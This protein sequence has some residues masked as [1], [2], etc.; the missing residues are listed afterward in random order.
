MA[1]VNGYTTDYVDGIEDQLIVSGAVVAGHLILTKN[2]ASTID[3]G[4]VV[5]SSPDASTTVKGIV[6]LADSTE[7]AALSDSTRAITPAGLAGVIGGINT[8]LSGK[9]A[10]DADLTTIAGLTPVA[11][12]FLQY[13]SGAWA[14]RTAAQ[15]AVD[16]SATALQPKDS[17]LTA[18][19]AIAPANDDVIQR[20]AGAWTNRTI[21]Q[22]GADLAVTDLQPKDSD[23][24]A[25]AAIAPTNDDI[26]QRKAGA[27]I[28]RTVAQYKSDLAL[29]NVD[30]T[31]DTA[32]PVSTAQQTALNLKANLAAPTI[33]GTAVF[34]GVISVT[35]KIVSPSVALSVSASLV[36]TDANLGN[37]FRVAATANFTLSNPTNP[38]DGQV[39]EWEI[40][41]DA[42]GSR[43]MT[44]G[45]KFA[46]GTDITSA[47]LTTTLNKRDFLTARY[48]STADKWYIRGFIKGY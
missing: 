5:S 44:L 43:V 29:N 1:T 21:T 24:T 10:S 17:D 13:K 23:L 46:L 41:Q 28:N 11:D 32:K 33:T 27:W 16:L 30:N 4:S 22:L 7:T 36:A 3:A 39:I 15:A 12:D 40:I 37:Y 8:S 48:N 45:S 47:T 19:A 26:I 42:T 6:E 18:I 2:D 35:G 31:A 34:S 25:I 14:N 38:S 9:Q 20:K